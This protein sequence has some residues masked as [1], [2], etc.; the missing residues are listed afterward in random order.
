[1]YRLMFLA[2]FAWAVDAC[3]PSIRGADP[4]TPLNNGTTILVAENGDSVDIVLYLLTGENRLT[5]GTVPGAS[6]GTFVLPTGSVGSGSNLRLAAQQAGAEHAFIS[7]PFNTPAGHWSRW[8]LQR[9]RFSALLLRWR[10]STSEGRD[11]RNVAAAL[12]SGA[13]CQASEA[14]VAGARSG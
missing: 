2:A 3:V 10:S 14:P 6:C 1:M 12:V 5:L 9:L 4:A 11:E 7:D 13:G 8:I